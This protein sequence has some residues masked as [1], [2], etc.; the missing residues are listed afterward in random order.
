M[1]PDP[2]GRPAAVDLCLPRRPSRGVSYCYQ[3]ASHVSV[4]ALTSGPFGR[5]P[6]RQVRHSRAA[7][8]GVAEPRLGRFNTPPRPSASGDAA[9]DA[10]Q[11]RTEA[12][13]AQ[14]RSR[15]QGVS[16]REVQQLINAVVKP[17]LAS[18]RNL[19]R[20]LKAVERQAGKSKTTTARPAGR[21]STK[22]RRAAPTRTRSLSAEG[23]PTGAQK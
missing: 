22:D 9:N 20:R 17:A 16:R 12:E 7:R 4:D 5:G 8:D 15:S 14:S 6:S 2:Y 3:A 10:P 13:M 23:T 21:T 1:P 19:E 18:V 11:Q